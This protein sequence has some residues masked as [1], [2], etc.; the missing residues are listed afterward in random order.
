MAT[1]VTANQERKTR[2]SIL[3]IRKNPF[4][5]ETS[6]RVSCKD[7]GNG[8]CEGWLWKKSEKPGFVSK[9]WKKY[10]FTLKE[11]SLYY[12][13]HKEDYMAQGIFKIPAFTIS[14]ACDKDCSRKFAFK[15]CNPIHG[16]FLFASERQEDM[17]KWMNKLQIACLPDLSRR[18]LNQID[19]V[20][21]DF[22]GSESE[23]DSSTASASSLQ[24]PDEISDSTST[25][26]SPVR[27]VRKSEL[28]F[29]VLA[30]ERRTSGLIEMTIRPGDPRTTLDRSINSKSKDTYLKHHLASLQRTLKDK[31]AQLSSLTDFLESSSP[32][33]SESLKNFQ[34]P[35]ID[36]AKILFVDNEDE[37]LDA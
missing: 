25:I 27:P 18:K 3:R 13:K 12:Y 24:S 15:A 30:A 33:T 6:R 23:D 22:S 17:A 8:D 32:I 20:P 28:D 35:F 36:D 2:E 21:E 26:E 31:E 29:S 11:S 19:S 9:D 7:L 1:S 5:K 10:W 4:R 34:S 14:P 37:S 16:T